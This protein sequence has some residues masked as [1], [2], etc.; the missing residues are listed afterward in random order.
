VSPTGASTISKRQS[1]CEISSH[2]G[3]RFFPRHRLHGLR[4]CCV[5]DVQGTTSIAS[6]WRKGFTRRAGESSVTDRN[7]FVSESISKTRLADVWLD[8]QQTFAPSRKSMPCS[9]TASKVLTPATQTRELH[10]AA[11]FKKNR[12]LPGNQSRPRFR[13]RNRLSATVEVLYASGEFT[14]ERTIALE[15]A[16]SRTRVDQTATL[17]A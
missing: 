13:L 16:A 17:S 6:S 5:D 1:A 2:A 8:D 7:F 15:L 12:F 11:A 3:L 10:C 9:A 14:R 4:A